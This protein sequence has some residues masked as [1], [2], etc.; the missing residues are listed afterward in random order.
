LPNRILRDGILTSEAVDSL[1][2]QAE[3]FYRRL[4]SVV[5]DYGRYYAKPSLLLATCFPL[6]IEK[7]TSIE[8]VK[9]LAEVCNT[10]PDPLLLVYEVEGKQY[11]QLLKFRQQVRAK[12]SKFPD[13]PADAMQT[14]RK[15]EADAH[16][17]VVVVGD[18][19]EG[20]VGV[21]DGL[22][23]ILPTNIPYKEIVALFNEHMGN[24]PRVRE[25]NNDRRKLIRAAWGGSKVRRDLKFW[26]SY[27]EEC[28]EDKFLNGTGPYTGEHANWR[29]TFDYL[30]RGKT[31]TRVYEKAMSDVR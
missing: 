11:L 9:F 23:T 5:D 15:C 25:L 31:I 6:R 21:G 2:F 7:L 10:K 26:K 13:P 18:V 8:I 12:K 22:P 16:L 24:L 28:S 20:V 19:V 4:M 27:F 30:M 17:D 1:S 29:P 14:L 3:V